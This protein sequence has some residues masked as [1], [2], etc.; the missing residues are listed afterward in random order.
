MAELIAVVMVRLVV[1]G[2]LSIFVFSVAKAV[3]EGYTEENFERHWLK[4]RDMGVHPDQEARVK[5]EYRS[6]K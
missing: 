3:W 1:G 2:F 5:Y 4:L 6:R